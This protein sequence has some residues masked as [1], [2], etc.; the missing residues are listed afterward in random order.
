VGGRALS[1]H[2]PL[3]WAESQR[4][5]RYTTLPRASK[6]RIY[7]MESYN[8]RYEAEQQADC[9]W[10]RHDTT[11]STDKEKDIDTRSNERF[12]C[13][14]R[15]P[16]KDETGRKTRPRHVPFGLKCGGMK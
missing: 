12:G 9:Y 13:K 11:V 6:A 14:T 3:V 1:I 15:Q 2:H 10:T 4:T 8:C 5:A 7:D 16:G